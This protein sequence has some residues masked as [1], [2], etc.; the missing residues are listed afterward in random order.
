MIP[1]P[2]LLHLDARL[3]LD[4]RHLEEL[5]GLAFSGAGEGDDLGQAL[6][7]PAHGGTWR[8]ETFADDLFVRDLV[9]A[10][11]RVAFSGREY[12]NN[13]TALFRVLTRPP[14]DL[15]TIR[16]RQGILAELHA[17]AE[18]LAAAQRLYA[19]LY[20]L[21][22]MFRYPGRMAQLDL[23]AFRMDVFRLVREAI[24]AMVTDF[25]GARSG[26]ARLHDA[27]LALRASDEVRTVD[28]LLDYEQ[29][30]AVLHVD[31]RVGASGRLTGL[32]VRSIEPNRDNPFYRSALRRRLGR[33]GAWLLH[34]L[35]L[36]DHDVMTR[37]VHAVYDSTAPAFMT[38]GQLLGQLEIYLAMEGLRRRVEAQGLA[39]CLPEVGDGGPLELTGLFNP[40][41]LGPAEPPVP[42][43]LR[44]PEARAVTLVTGPNSGGKTRLLQAIGLAQ[45]LGQG[46]F[47]APAAHARLPRVRGMF[48]SLV[49]RETAE[50]SE[51]RLGRELS[52]IRQLF[53]T[54]EDPSL[55][56][57]DE[58]CSGTNPSEGVEVF[59]LVLRLLDR[60]R[61]VGFVTSH[62]LEYVQGLSADPPIPDLRFLRVEVDGH[63]R[64][65]YRFVPGVADS[66]LA[67]LTAERMG[68]TFEGIAAA[69]E[70][71]RAAAGPG[72]GE[73][74]PAAAGA[75]ARR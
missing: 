2:D 60:V 53:D 63:R 16:F 44:Q 38:L 27:G 15:E 37:L 18:R 11:L 25:A 74:E 70:R 64:S 1:I 69:I 22:N 61:P 67:A 66:S 71:R 12:A 55:V 41:L 36:G 59:S 43:D 17:D 62:F 58:L 31:L 7:P 45:L 21:M 26:L 40:L 14:L 6:A 4:R 5:L 20:D 34:G 72:R 65:T 35:R 46:G 3:D 13:P 23:G 8:T 49:E 56:L 68:I 33:L 48:V 10:H 28:A 19:R 75:A 24:E 54:V 47:Y 50:R 52:R 42:C 32:E 39:M 57:V 29:R 9:A 51:G 30:Q 73:T